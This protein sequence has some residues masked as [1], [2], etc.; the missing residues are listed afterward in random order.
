MDY[1][2]FQ[3]ADIIRE[4]YTMNYYLVLDLVKS[5]RTGHINGLY[6]RNINTGELTTI[7]WNQMPNFKLEA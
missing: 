3:I 4:K 7:W 1:V 5:E 6:T 2:P